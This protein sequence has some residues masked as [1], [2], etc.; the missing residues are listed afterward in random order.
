MRPH[1]APIDAVRALYGR[2]RSGQLRPDDVIPLSDAT[3]DNVANSIKRMRTDARELDRA[4]PGFRETY[5]IFRVFDS[6]TVVL[7]VGAHWG[8]SIAAMRHQG[9]R[10]RIVSIEAMAANAAGLDMLKAIEA[11]QYDWINVA[12]G[13]EDGTLILYVPIVNGHAA[14]GLTS[15]GQ[16]LDDE[17]A[18]NA[19]AMI[20]WY[21]PRKEGRHTFQLAIATVRAARIDAILAERG[22]TNVT[23]VKMDIEGHEGPALRGAVR[24]FTEHRPLLMVESANR[25]PETVAAMTNYGYFHCERQDRR[26]APHP[27][28]S[29]ANDG[30]FLHPSRVDEY[31]RLGIFEDSSAVRS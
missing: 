13:A 6:D 14:V 27:S 12:A 10:S 25:N 16:T 24:L 29:Y 1:D 30:F 22:I 15:T 11:G 31:R 4:L 19:V 23:A 7:D 21:P 9:C 18:K 20:P 8:Y 26:L 5:D 3:F 2:L 17:G 28:L